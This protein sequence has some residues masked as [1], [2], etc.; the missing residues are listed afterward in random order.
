MAFLG[1]RAVKYCLETRGSCVGERKKLEGKGGGGSTEI[2]Q[3]AEE[4]EGGE[5]ETHAGWESPRRSWLSVH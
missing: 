2:E 5:R 1:F 4:R 3:A